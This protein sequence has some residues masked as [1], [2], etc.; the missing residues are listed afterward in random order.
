MAEIRFP[1]TELPEGARKMVSV[2]G[3]D[4][5]VF[6][7]GG[8]LF[9]LQN[10]CPHQWGPVCEG[11]LLGAMESAGPGHYD[12]VPDSYRLRCPWHGWEFDIKTGRGWTDVKAR[13]RRFYPRREEDEVVV[14]TSPG[15]G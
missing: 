15:T 13:V 14:S 12:Y 7:V 2:G 4:V 8:E 3:I 9:A 1:A 5:G 10:R 6:N 11:D